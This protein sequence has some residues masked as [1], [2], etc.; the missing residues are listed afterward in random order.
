[1]EK[2]DGIVVRL[3]HDLEKQVCNPLVDGD[4]L[5]AGG[6]IRT[7]LGAFAG[8]H[9]VH[10]R[11]VV[12][13]EGLRK[14]LCHAFLASHQRPAVGPP[15]TKDLAGWYS[16]VFEVEHRPNDVL[17]TAEPWSARSFRPRG[18]PRRAR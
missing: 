5:L 13:H 12:L 1:M 8:H 14:A 2:H 11:H 15:L 16:G 9:D 3:A 4:L 18:V 7:R 17:D 10:D 6:T